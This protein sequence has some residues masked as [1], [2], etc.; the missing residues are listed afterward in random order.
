MAAR[1]KMAFS[2]EMKNEIC[3]CRREDGR[4]RDVVL[5]L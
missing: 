4:N 1:R 5:P 3:R 2:S